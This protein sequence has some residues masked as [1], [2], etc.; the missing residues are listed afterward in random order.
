MALFRHV[1]NL[2]LVT[3]SIHEYPVRVKIA[4]SDLGHCSCVHGGVVGDLVPMQRDGNQRSWD[5]NWLMWA[6][7]LRS[8][9]LIKPAV[10]GCDGELPTRF[11]G[12][13]PGNGKPDAPMIL[14]GV[15]IRIRAKQDA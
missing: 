7:L 3:R 13:N 1:L 4:H 9:K 12:E 10:L 11:L 8:V 2:K 6:R 14:T 5:E 15:W